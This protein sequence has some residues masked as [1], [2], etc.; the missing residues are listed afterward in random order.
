METGL[1]PLLV[2]LFNLSASSYGCGS[3]CKSTSFPN[4]AIFRDGNLCMHGAASQIEGFIIV[5]IHRGESSLSTAL[6]FL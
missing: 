5:Q 6:M 3:S 4:I 1:L 2:I